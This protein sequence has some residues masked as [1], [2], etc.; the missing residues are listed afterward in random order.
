[1]ELL[2]E[3]GGIPKCDGELNAFEGDVLDPGNDPEE[4]GSAMVEVLP[5]DPHAV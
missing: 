1:M 4:G 3:V 5:R 2:L